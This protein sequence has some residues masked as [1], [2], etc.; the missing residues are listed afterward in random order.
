MKDAI[1]LAGLLD[2]GNVKAFL[3]VIRA[4]EG[5]PDQ[6]GY[7]RHFGGRLFDSFPSPA[8]LFQHVIEHRRQ[9]DSEY[10]N[11]QHST[12]NGHA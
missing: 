8:Q 9:K 5:T 6:D 12:E 7:R 2:D 11:P 1:A 3:A 10:G 4:G